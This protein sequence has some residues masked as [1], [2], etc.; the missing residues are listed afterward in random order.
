MPSPVPSAPA[1]VCATCSRAW[2]DVDDIL[3]DDTMAVLVHTTTGEVAE[4]YLNEGYW[5]WANDNPVVV[6]VVTHWREMPDGPE[7]PE[8]R[9]S[10]RRNEIWQRGL[11]EA[12]LDLTPLETAAAIIEEDAACL[13]ECNT[14]GGKWDAHSTRQGGTEHGAF[15]VWKKM[16]RAA[17]DLRKMGERLNDQEM[18]ADRKS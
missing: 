4:G 5:H 12:P 17:E 3:P 2:I 15:T 14:F 11:R 9:E 8:Q 6:D 18:R 10:R 16:V 7:T 13:K 1:A